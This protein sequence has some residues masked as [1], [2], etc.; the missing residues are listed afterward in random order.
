MSQDLDTR[1]EQLCD[2][3]GWDFSNLRALYINCTLKRSPQ[4][5][6]PR[7]SLTTRLRSCAGLASLSTS[8]GRSTM[9]SRPASTQI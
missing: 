1:Q 9:R 5:P 6:T 8:S 7:D 4:S 3:A 2:D